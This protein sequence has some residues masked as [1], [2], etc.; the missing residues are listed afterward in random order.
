SGHSNRYCRTGCWT[1]PIGEDKHRHGNG[2]GGESSEC[3]SLPSLEGWMRR[4]E[5]IAALGG[6]ALP[7]RR[8]RPP[9]RRTARGFLTQ[10][11]ATPCTLKISLVGCTIAKLGVRTSNSA[12]I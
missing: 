1:S 5:F 6:A 7:P 11:H 9:S 2:H 12:P 3:D 4:R 8:R 10:P